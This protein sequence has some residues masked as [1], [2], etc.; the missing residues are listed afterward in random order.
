MSDYRLKQELVYELE[1]T[2]R[3]KRMNLSLLEVLSSTV[4]WLLRY[5]K[6][7]GTAPPD[8]ERIESVIAKA[9]SIMKQDLGDHPLSDT[10]DRHPDKPTVYKDVH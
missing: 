5:C 10:Q 3:V 9:E 8:L 1:E 6:S 2:L 7:N 4:V